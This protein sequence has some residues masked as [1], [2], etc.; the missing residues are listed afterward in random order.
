M[1][2]KSFHKDME[3][4]LHYENKGVSWPPRCDKV[5]FELKLKDKF[6][7]I[8]SSMETFFREVFVHWLVVYKYFKVYKPGSLFLM[9]EFGRQT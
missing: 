2:S 5:W 4:L 1:N 9:D 8:L 7:S 6:T 3:R